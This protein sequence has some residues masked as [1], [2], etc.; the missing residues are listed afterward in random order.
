MNV[1]EDGLY[2]KELARRSRED[3]AFKGVLEVCLVPV[4]MVILL[5]HGALYLNQMTAIGDEAGV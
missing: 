4:K 3:S 2:V 1:V 5:K